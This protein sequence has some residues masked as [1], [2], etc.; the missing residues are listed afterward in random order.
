MD[1]QTQTQAEIASDYAIRTLMDEAANHG[2]GDQVTLCRAALRG[3]D[4][5]RQL[6]AAAIIA[7]QG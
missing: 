1:K 6:C 2:D 3:D 5:A 4:E 7:G